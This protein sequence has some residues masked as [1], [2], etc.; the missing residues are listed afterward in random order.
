MREFQCLLFVL[1]RSYIGYYIICMTVP[2][3]VLFNSHKIDTAY[4][5]QYN[6]GLISPWYNWKIGQ[7]DII[8]D[9]PYFFIIIFLPLSEW[10]FFFL[11]SLIP[12]ML[13]LKYQTE[14]KSGQFCKQRALGKAIKRTQNS[15]VMC[16]LIVLSVRRM[17]EFLRKA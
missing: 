17:K 13:F 9:R 3:N 11:K 12:L 1:K 10:I 7:K 6:H 5:A 16:T 15:H 14:F 2:L 4:L 8:F